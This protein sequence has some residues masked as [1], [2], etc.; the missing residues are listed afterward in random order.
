MKDWIQPTQKPALVADPNARKDAGDAPLDDGV[1]GAD[2]NAAGFL[3]NA[4]DR[5]PAETHAP[6][7]EP[8][9]ADTDTGQP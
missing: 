7:P 3:K 5:K 9:A 8:R 2:E 1:P 6:T 4:I